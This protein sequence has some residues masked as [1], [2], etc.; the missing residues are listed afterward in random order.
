ME[1]ELQE[2]LT[3]L[4]NICNYLDA[5]LMNSVRRNTPFTHRSETEKQSS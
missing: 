1:K 2:L 3:K 4:T 5:I